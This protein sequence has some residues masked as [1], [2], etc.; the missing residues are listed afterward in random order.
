MFVD[1]LSVAHMGALRT[2]PPATGAEPQR[3][4]MLSAHLGWLSIRD[5]S[6]PIDDEAFCV[7]LEDD[8]TFRVRLRD[9]EV[10]CAVLEDDAEFPIK[11][12]D[13][14][15]FCVVLTDDDEVRIK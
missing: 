14:E 12:R 9:D 13:D 15:V 10:F 1:M 8:E 2:A 5:G 4:A 3:D 6:E 11:L 7:M